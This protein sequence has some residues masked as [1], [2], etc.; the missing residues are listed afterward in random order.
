MELD[1]R[2]SLSLMGGLELMEN[3]KTFCDDVNVL[4]LVLD[5]SY[6]S[7]YNC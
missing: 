3:Q 4:Y 7:T 6:I 5:E 1:I 2:K